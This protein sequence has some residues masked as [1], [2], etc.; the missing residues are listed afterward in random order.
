MNALWSLSL[1]V[2][3]RG[4]ALARERAWLLAW[5]DQDTLHLFNRLGQL[6]AQWQA[7]G[8]LT[9][10]ACA[11]DGSSY[12]AVAGQGQVWLLGPDLKTRWERSVVQRGTAVALEP[13]GQAVAVADGGG[14]LQLFDQLGRALWRTVNPRALQYL[15]F[16]PEKSALVGSADFGLVACFD[17][18]G[19]CLWRDGLVAH[20][21]SLATSGDGSTIALACFSEGVCCYAVEGPRL[22]HVPVAGPC[23][24]AAL[25]Y[26]GVLLLTANLE[27]RL[28]LQ[29]RDGTIRAET[30]LDSPPTALALGPLGDYAA[31]AQAEGKLQVLALRGPGAA[32][33]L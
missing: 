29:E 26:D 13:L 28:R 16:V 11:D 8:A 15:A 20:I 22:R 17:R 24:L 27:N 1:P 12:A 31:L 9:A 25:S 4:L 14:G 7:P 32:N 5:D 19:K 33:G 30:V 2:S 18:V 6:Q 21:G 23:R 10:V 3:W